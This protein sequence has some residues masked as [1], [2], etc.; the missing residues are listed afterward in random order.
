MAG[1]VPFDGDGHPAVGDVCAQ[2]QRCLTNLFAVVKL[3]GF[4]IDDIHQVTIYV[5]GDHQ[6]LRD[7]W[8]EVTA[9]FDA[10]VPPATV[11]GVSLLGYEDQLVEIDAH[12]ERARST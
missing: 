9:R 11:L 8:R 5:V 1:Q 6:N 7:A 3:H 10:N 4:E 12:V 2:T